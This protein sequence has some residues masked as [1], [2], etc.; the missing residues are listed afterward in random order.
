M[1]SNVGLCICGGKYKLR[2]KLGVGGFGM[3]YLATDMDTGE[4]VAVKI[5][6]RMHMYAPS[7]HGEVSLYEKL[8]GGHCIP[9][10]YM[11]GK[12]LGHDFVV[13]DLLGPSLEDLFIYCGQQFSL[14]TVLMIADQLL[15]ICQY[16]HSKEVVHNDIKPG[17]LMMGTGRNGNRI[18]IIDFGSA[19]YRAPF[20][21]TNSKGIGGT[22]MYAS[23]IGG[24][25]GSPRNDLETIGYVLIQ[26]LQSRLPWHEESEFDDCEL[27]FEKKG[28]VSLEDLCKNQPQ[29][30]ARYMEYVRS[31]EWDDKPNYSY[32][33][34]IFRNL[35]LKRGFKY[36]NVFD[37][38]TKLYAE[39]HNKSQK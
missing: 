17:N 15:C 13:M 28:S 5:E 19:E 11:R 20:Q 35:Y 2:Y 12:E 36:D 8:S 9:T 33:R 32:L 16:I 34:K 38:T 29:E 30:F 24:G 39:L 3:V 10:I 23:I 14:K 22:L 18:Y 7:S 31:L 27:V 26:F 6:N 4:D 21:E 25:T 37:W 1:T